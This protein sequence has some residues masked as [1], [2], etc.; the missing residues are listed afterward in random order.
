V[1]KCFVISVVNLIEVYPMKVIVA[2]TYE[3][4]DK[5]AALNI[6]SEQITHSGQLEKNTV[7]LMFCHYDFV[8]S[9]VAEYIAKNLPFPVVGGTTTLVGVSKDGKDDNRYTEGQF[10]LV[11]LVISA[12]DIEFTPVLSGKL[13]KDLSAE[14]ICENML[15]SVGKQKLGIMILPH[16]LLTDPENLV[17]AVTRH[18][19]AQL[20]GG[21][22]VDDSPTYIENCFVIAKGEAHCDRAVILFMKGNFEPHFANIIVSNEKYLKNTAVITEAKG[23]EIISLDGKPVTDFL[24]ELGFSLTGS[25]ENAV[26]GAVMLVDDGDGDTYGRSMMFLT[27]ENHLFVGGKVTTGATVSVA[28]FDRKSVLHASDETS[29]RMMTAHP[30]AKL[31]IV[32]SCESRHIV[33][34][35]ETFDGEDLLRRQFPGVPFMLAYAGG[36]ICPSSASTP[37]KPINRFFNQ[38]YCVCVID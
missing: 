18:T 32:A 33:L 17:E 30:G 23:N 21:T 10:R 9:G 11:V 15:D 12:D 34:G 4:D 3:V 6:I 38:S 7:G 27:P 22:S 5:E 24:K 16:I 8:S 36:E 2:R 25:K 19:N 20:F 29:N 26:N 28:M 1:L 35:S 13:S 31:A 37:E 14:E